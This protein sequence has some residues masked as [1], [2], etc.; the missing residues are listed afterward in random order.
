MVI[1]NVAMSE[2]TLA[3]IDGNPK[4]SGACNMYPKV[5]NVHTIAGA[6]VMM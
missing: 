3:V 6:N 4:P 2:I 1:T 5:I